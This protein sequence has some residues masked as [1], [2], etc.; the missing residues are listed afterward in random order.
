MLCFKLILACNCLIL[1]AY[2]FE[3]YFSNLIAG[4]SN[5]SWYEVFLWIVTKSLYGICALSISFLIRNLII[6]NFGLDLQ[7]YQEWICACFPGFMITALLKLLIDNHADMIIEPA[8]SLINN[9]QYM[10]GEKS[11]SINNIKPKNL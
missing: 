2:L 11:D 8:K 10:G 7:K 5:V 1:T 9:Y 6:H 3:K 4:I